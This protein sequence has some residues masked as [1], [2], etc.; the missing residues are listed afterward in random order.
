MACNPWVVVAKFKK[1]NE[2]LKAEID[3]LKKRVAA[4]EE[5]CA[6]LEYDNDE[7]REESNL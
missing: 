3:E 6:Q 1:S 7:L 2:A 4:L 5:K